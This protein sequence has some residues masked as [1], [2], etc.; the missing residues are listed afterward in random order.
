MTMRRGCSSGLVSLKISSCH[1]LPRQPG[2]RAPTKPLAHKLK[3]GIARRVKAK[4]EPSAKG[5]N[6]S[7]DVEENAST[8]EEA[9][10]KAA[11]SESQGDVKEKTS[12]GA[13]F[14]EIQ[15]VKEETSIET[16]AAFSQDGKENASAEAAAAFSQDIKEEAATSHSQRVQEEELD[17]W[18]IFTG[19]NKKKRKAFEA[20]EKKQR[21]REEK[22][23]K[24]A[25]QRAEK[26]ERKQPKRETTARAA[27]KETTALEAQSNAQRETTAREA[28]RGKK[29][30]KQPED[31]GKLEHQLASREEQQQLMEAKMAQMVS[32]LPPIAQDAV[33]RNAKLIRYA[34]R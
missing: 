7:Q 33:P 28:Q 20:T 2:A 10:L 29:Q 31:L 16:A 34:V 8:E 12:T 32:F 30:R 14:S 13:A 6:E 3:A 9:A 11:F 1:M 5:G 22:L 4:E 17:F 15:K 18:Q 24:S 25:A 23:S 26:Q 27:Q 19:E 21:Q